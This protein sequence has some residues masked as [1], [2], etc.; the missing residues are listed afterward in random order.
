MPTLM[1]GFGQGNGAVPCWNKSRQKL[2]LHVPF[3]V[4]HRNFHTE[5]SI[6]SCYRSK[7]G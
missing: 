3:Q 4:H 5:L 1:Q 7:G 6:M 2:L